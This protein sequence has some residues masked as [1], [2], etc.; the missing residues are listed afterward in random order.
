VYEGRLVFSP[1]LY[2]KYAKSGYM[3]H[4]IGEAIELEMHPHNM[5]REDDLNL[6]A[7][8]FYI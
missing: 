4:L 7:P 2:G 1:Y 3:D 6:L 5:N 8:E